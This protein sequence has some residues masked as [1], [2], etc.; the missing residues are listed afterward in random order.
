[1]KSKSNFTALTTARFIYEKVIFK[2]GKL[3]RTHTDQGV[4]FKAEVTKQIKSHATT[5]H[6]IFC[7][8]KGK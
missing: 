4:N 5:Y 2:Y 7:G 6:P 1:M 3:K 8:R